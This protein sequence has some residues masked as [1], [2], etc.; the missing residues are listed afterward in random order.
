LTRK[1]RQRG[2]SSWQ[3]AKGTEIYEEKVEA[4]SALNCHKAYM[5]TKLRARAWKWHFWSADTDEF[6]RQFGGDSAGF[7]QKSPTMI[8]VN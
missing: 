7:S 2:Y 8:G 5:R 6:N 1:I 4:V 3:D